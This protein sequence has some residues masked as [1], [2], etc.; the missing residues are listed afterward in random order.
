MPMQM[1]GYQ[2]YQDELATAQNTTKAN[3]VAKAKKK[4]DLKQKLQQVTK[5]L[6]EKTQKLKKERQDSMAAKRGER[7]YNKKLK[8]VKKHIGAQKPKSMAVAGV[9][10]FV[11]APLVISLAMGLQC[12]TELKTNDKKQ[13]FT[14]LYKEAMREVWDDRHEWVV[15]WTIFSTI[16]ITCGVAS[17]ND[18]DKRSID[19]DHAEAIRILKLLEK[20]KL[21]DVNIQRVTKVLNESYIKE[22]V[23][24]MLKSLSKVDR[25]YFDNL[26]AGNLNDADYETCVA[27]VS[28]YLKSHP[29]EYN[30]VI[31]IVDEA[32]LPPEIVKKYG[33]GKTIS[34]AAA[35][36]MQ[37]EK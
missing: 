30:K 27:I 15:F 21:G 36:A 26:A 2:A 20:L 22:F 19:A 24:K 37:F 28:G 4:V 12:L 8:I 10:G 13:S 32:T 1:P 31:A 5:T 23:N 18:D 3:R 17:A 14:K 29:K 9:A 33:K 7:L 11:F 34:F 35:K 6:S 25:G 16:I